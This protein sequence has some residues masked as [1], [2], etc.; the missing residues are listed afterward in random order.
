METIDKTVAGR[1]VLHSETERDGGVGGGG[2]CELLTDASG[3][4]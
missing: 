2:C 1:L 4:G 3:A